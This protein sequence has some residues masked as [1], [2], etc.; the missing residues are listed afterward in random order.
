MVGRRAFGKLIETRLEGVPSIFGELN[1]D[2]SFAIVF[3]DDLQNAQV[4]ENLEKKSPD[5]YEL[6]IAD[7]KSSNL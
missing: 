2:R 1:K 3:S 6:K 7:Q 4:V 5:Y